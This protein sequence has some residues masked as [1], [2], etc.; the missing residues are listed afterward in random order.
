SRNTSHSW[1]VK[2]AF[3]AMSVL[4]ALNCRSSCEHS[5][6]TQE[7][8]QQTGVLADGP[9]TGHRT[10]RPGQTLKSRRLA[11]RELN[12]AI[13]GSALG[14]VIGCHGVL[15]AETCGREPITGHTGF[16]EQVFQC[17]GPS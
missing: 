10:T 1:V 11:E 3:V 16:Y 15:T 13:S 4:L 14:G 7:S 6:T 5:Q 17:I 12:P 8:G 2:S 9:L